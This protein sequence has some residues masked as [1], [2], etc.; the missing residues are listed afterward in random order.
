[1]YELEVKAKVDDAATAVATLTAAG[2]A[3]GGAIRQ[4]DQIFARSVS[5]IVSPASGTVILRLRHE[6][7]TVTLNAKQHRSNELDCIEEETVVMDPVAAAR[8]L[9]LLGLHPVTRIA[10]VRRSA[11]VG[12][13]TICVDEVEGLGAFVE[14][15][16]LFTEAPKADEQATLAGELV[17]L[18]G[19]DAT[20]VRWGY[21]RIKLAGRWA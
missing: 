1:M 4:E 5:D 2:F 12:D 3:F 21:D 18:L 10:K 11:T 9:R 13:R 7:N 19:Q 6:G 16:R 20:L 17:E 8:L 15:E 14:L